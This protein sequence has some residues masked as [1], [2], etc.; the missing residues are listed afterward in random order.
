ML[1]DDESDTVRASAAWALTQVG[2]EEA[3]DAATQYTE[4]RSYLVQSEAEW[5]AR[6][7]DDREDSEKGDAEREQPA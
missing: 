7:L 1:R 4:D 6:A 2:T 3:L 5:A